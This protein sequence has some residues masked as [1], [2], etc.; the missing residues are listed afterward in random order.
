MKRRNLLRT[1]DK[2]LKGNVHGEILGV[3]L[4]LQDRSK[5]HEYLE[6]NLT[7]PAP[8]LLKGASPHI[9]NAVRQSILSPVFIPLSGCSTRVV[10]EVDVRPNS[11]HCESIVFWIWG[12]PK[13]KL[14]SQNDSKT[15]YL[16]EGTS[17]RKFNLSDKKE[18]KYIEAVVKTNSE[19]LKSWE[20]AEKALSSTR[21][22]GVDLVRD[23]FLGGFI[24][25]RS[26][27][28]FM[29]SITKRVK[30]IL[31][32][33]TSSLLYSL[34]KKF[35][36]NYSYSKNIPKAIG[37]EEPEEI[38]ENNSITNE[39][40][41][42][43]SGIQDNYFCIEKRES[44]AQSLSESKEPKIENSLRRPSMPDNRE[45]QSTGQKNR[46]FVPPQVQQQL[47]QLWR[48]WTPKDQ[49][50]YKKIV[51]ASG[52][53]T[54]IYDPTRIQFK[55]WIGFTPSQI[56]RGDGI[57]SV[58][59]IRPGLSKQDVKPL[60]ETDLDKVVNEFKEQRAKGDKKIT[61]EF[62][63]KLGVKHGF[64]TGQYNLARSKFSIIYYL[65]Q[66]SCRKVDGHGR[67]LQC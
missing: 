58:R 20:E 35:P 30:E 61:K 33:N 9:M 67:W 38:I 34:V 63:K 24:D 10:I 4:R 31:D 29:S 28:H 55:D 15:G 32:K 23:A 48:L 25:I 43:D 41:Y 13:S 7:G 1:D 2:D 39:K 12:T 8:K 14:Q 45:T 26:D 46:P 49:E 37:N 51:D 3:P 56:G 16:R 27:K 54:I 21:Q 40:N 65:L 36:K 52:K 59:V 22:L 18:R 44:F 66:L 5:I 50:N 42:G 62:L 11:H 53:D 57:K 6:A 19:V 60:S 64:T 47:T 17:T